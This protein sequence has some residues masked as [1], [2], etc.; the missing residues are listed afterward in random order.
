MQAAGSGGGVSSYIVTPT[1]QTGPGVPSARAGRYTPDVSFSGAC[2]DPYF[3]CMA[4]TGA[5]CAVGSNGYFYFLGMCGTSASAP[6]MAGVAA[7][8]DQ[9]M[10]DPQGNIN[11]DIY[12]LAQNQPSTFHD[13]TPS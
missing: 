10:Q 6:S 5:S 4:A 8:L 7:L 11:P 9:K 13:T 3:M 1:W 2:H 12:A